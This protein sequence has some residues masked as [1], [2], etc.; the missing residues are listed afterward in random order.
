MSDKAEKRPYVFTVYKGEKN[1][2]IVYIGT[3]IQSPSD[4]FRWHKANGKLLHFT[5]L[6]QHASKDEMLDEEFRL[7]KK[8]KPLMN[9]ITQRR[10]NFNAKLSQDELDLRKDNPEWCQFC[11]RRRVNKGYKYCYWCN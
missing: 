5:V 10:Q 11:F 4:R 8:H 3:T 7:I 2:K 6:S 9:K 1:N